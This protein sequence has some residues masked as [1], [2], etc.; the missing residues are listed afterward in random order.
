MSL[1][2][3]GLLF[4]GA[5]KFRAGDNDPRTE[6]VEQYD[7]AV[8][9]W[10]SSGVHEFKAK[11]EGTTMLNFNV[12]GLPGGKSPGALELITS[13]GEAVGTLPDSEDDYRQYHEGAMLRSILDAAHSPD[14]VGPS[15]V[16]VTMGQMGFELP[17][18]TCE[19]V[20]GSVCTSRSGK[21][22]C[23]NADPRWASKWAYLL[24]VAFVV[25][26][27]PLYSPSDANCGLVYQRG[28]RWFESEA[29]AQQLCERSRSPQQAMS[30]KVTARSA[31][32]PWVV[33][34][35]LTACSRTFGATAGEYVRDGIIFTIAGLCATSICCSSL[36]CLSKELYHI[37]RIKPD[38]Q[39]GLTSSKVHPDVVGNCEQEGHGQ[40]SDGKPRVSDDNPCE[41][42]QTP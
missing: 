42:Y 8:E 26:T 38:D 10:L 41:R 23:L 7:Q 34:G 31:K 13:G 17:F 25:N 21:G 1:V 18:F 4:G 32:D 15:I 35:R 27:R 12:S 24:E 29:E 9:E 20:E 11:H 16:K 28:D 37:F 40:T 2:S 3:F 5:M 22:E 30:F 33:A 19:I 36:Y 6:L 14:K 39:K